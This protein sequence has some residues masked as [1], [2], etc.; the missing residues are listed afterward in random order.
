[1]E[2]VRIGIIGVGQIGKVHLNEY[3]DME[4]VEVVAVCDVNEQEVRRVAEKFNIPN[5]YTDYHEMLQ[6]DDI[7]AVDV[8]LHNNF[9]AQVTIDAFRAGKH[10]YCEKPIAGTFAD[11]QAMVN[12]AREWD[13]KLHIQMF[14][15]YQ[16]ETIA[17]KSLIEDGKLGKLYHA[18]STGFRRRGRPFVDGYGT[19]FFTRKEFASGGALYDMGVY[20]ISQMLYLLGLPEV[21]RI[22]GK[23]YQEMA[24]DSARQQESGFDVEELG[25]GFVR[26]E[27]GITMDII[28]AWSVHLGKFEGGSVLGSE[29]GIQ[30]PSYID[31]SMKSPF[32]YHTT[33]SDMDFD[34]TLDMP[35]MRERRRRLLANEEAYSS[36]H[37]H[38][39]AALNNQVPLLPTAELAL[40]TS[41][42][43][44]GIY[45]SDHLEREVAADEVAAGSLLT[46]QQ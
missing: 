20:H 44:E 12:A 2:R 19:K 34:S 18:R 1:M 41:L 33:I 28:E 42:I 45:L 37:H 7:H 9:H 26:F 40:K 8:C 5:V 38:W 23:V 14:T 32:S 29:G 4:S 27:N 6:R 24:M 31:G 21:K 43:S 30:L 46:I 39:I 16:S 3:A 25:L 22:S 35:A 17:A 10:V 15:L 11:G 36:S 13:K